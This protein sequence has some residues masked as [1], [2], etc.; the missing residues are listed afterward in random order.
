MQ[1]D[2]GGVQLLYY[3][4]QLFGCFVFMVFQS[5]LNA[6]FLQFRNDLPEC[7][8]CLIKDC[9]IKIQTDLSKIIFPFA[10]GLTRFIAV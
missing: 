10:A 9:G 4:Y 1:A 3:I 8:Y 2:P 6:A 5:D 7:G